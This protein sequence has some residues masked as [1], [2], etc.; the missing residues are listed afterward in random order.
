MIIPGFLWLLD[1]QQKQQDDATHQLQ[2][3]CQ[4]AGF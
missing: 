2:D 1:D 4:F 3:P